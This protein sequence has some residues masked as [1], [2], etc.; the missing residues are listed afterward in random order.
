[1]FVRL[2]R[3]RAPADRVAAFRSAYAADG[4]WARLFG[5]AAGFLGTEL[6]RSATDPEIFV[7]V[8]RWETRGAWTAFLERHGEAYRALD[9]ELEGLTSEERDLGD[10]ET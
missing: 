9:R 1:M 2:W 7:T 10:F 4:A 3:F 5:K 8:D 6:L